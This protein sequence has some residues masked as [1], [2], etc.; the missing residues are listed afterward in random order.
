MP[1][2]RCA[3]VTLPLCEIVVSLCVHV[4][5]CE[6]VRVGVVVGLVG[7]AGGVGGVG[8]GRGVGS[9]RVPH[10]LHMFIVFKEVN[11]LRALDTAVL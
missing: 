3:R 5:G 1:L 6:G 4:C 7:G 10:A 11:V 2:L 8:W 9:V